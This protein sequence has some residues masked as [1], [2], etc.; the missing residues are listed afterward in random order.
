MTGPTGATAA[1]TADT[2]RNGLERVR[3]LPGVVFASAACCVPLQNRISFPFDI[4]GRPTGNTPYLGGG[5]WTPV[6]PGYFDVF[7]IPLK[8]GRTFN[9]R[10][11]DKST[12]VVVINETMAKQFWKDDPLKDRVIL[13]KVLRELKDEPAR[14]I[15]G[16]VGDVRD[17]GLNREPRPMM[18]VPQ[19]QVTDALNGLMVRLLP[20]AWVV[21]TQAEPYALVPAI[22]GQLLQATGLPV[23]DIHSMDE[24][25]SLSTARQRFNMLLMTVFGIAALLLAAIGIYGLMAYSVEERTQEIGIRLALGAETSQ[26]RTMIVR[27]GMGLALAGVLGGTGAAWGLARLIESLLFGVK[28]RDPLVFLA[29]PV[30][31]C[32]VAL[33]AVWLPANRASRVSPMESLHYE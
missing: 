15:V 17:G 5:E 18:Y 11:H 3:A 7:Q 29:V 23:S 25:V 9:E 14:Q 32:A 24:V 8:R 13:G 33:L 28:A 21:R 31:L 20:V 4:V 10:D 30:V 12:P 26:V 27:Q 22:R 2:I 6:A 16:I 19:A 1:G